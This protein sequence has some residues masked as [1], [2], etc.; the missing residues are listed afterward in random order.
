ML[1][2]RA[3]LATATGRTGLSELF[4]AASAKLPSSW[5]RLTILTWHRIAKDLGA[6]FDRGVVAASPEQFDRQIAILKQNFSVIDT[7]ALVKY[8]E[9]GRPLPP[10]PVLLTFDDGYRDNLTLALPILQRHGVKAVFFIPTG[11][12]GE[13]RLFSWELIS[14]LLARCH[15]PDI[16]ITYPESLQFFLGDETARLFASRELTRISRTRPGVDEAR[17]LKELAAA[18][19]VHW[20]ATIERGIADELILDWD[21]VRAL[22]EAGMEVQSH[23]HSHALFPTISA[24]Q[25]QREAS[26]SRQVMEAQTGQ[27]Q[28]AI[29]Y[30]AGAGL[31]PGQPSYDAV[32]RAGYK[33]GF[34]LG[35]RSCRLGT[36]S[37][38]LNLPR[39]TS[40]P[41]LTED[42]FR[43][44]L[45]FPNFLC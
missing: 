38:W 24:E 25:V 11:F 16:R 34:C 10:N 26:Q 7:A 18:C 22:A 29:A 43:G 19:E 14:A 8:R 27:A 28:V 39:L 9:E 15:R 12:I 13:G 23:G 21:G 17:F 42:R 1:R 35:F 30:P 44:F 20:D 37:D 6:G 45:A 3:R 32:A 4:L 36:I 2:I 33:L 41:E 40:H 5:Q 31:A